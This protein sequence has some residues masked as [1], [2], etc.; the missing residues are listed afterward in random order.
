MRVKTKES[1]AG[2]M[3]EPCWPRVFQLTGAA[4]RHCPGL[5]GYCFREHPQSLRS[6]LH[7]GLGRIC[8]SLPIPENGSVPRI[9]FNSHLYPP[10][11]SGPNSYY[12]YL[13]RTVPVHL[14]ASRSSHGCHVAS[15][16]SLVKSNSLFTHLISSQ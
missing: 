3:C 14:S 1:T 9:K 15:G 7:Q 16:K 11:T 13:D 5:T 10:Q 2:G 4:G 6:S 8:V 12:H